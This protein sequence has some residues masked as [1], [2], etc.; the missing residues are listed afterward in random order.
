MYKPTKYKYKMVTVFM[1]TKAD[2][3]QRPDNWE[4]DKPIFAEL[5]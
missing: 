3:L 1:K 5:Y 2:A 4:T